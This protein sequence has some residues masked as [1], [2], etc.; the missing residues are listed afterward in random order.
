MKVPISWLREFVEINVTPYELADK[1]VSCGFEVEEII[2]EKESIKNVVT[3]K[4]VDIT[5]HPDATK[6]LICKIDVARGDLLQIVTG[7]NNVFVDA[8]VPVCLDGA[9]L[10]DGKKITTGELR[11]VLSQGMLCSGSELNLDEDDFEGAGVNGIFIMPKDTPIG[12]DIKDYIGCDDIILDISITA[13]RPDCNSIIGIAKEVA[14]LLNT[15]FIE[16]TIKYTTKCD[17]SI[18]VDVIAKD[19]CPNYIAH[20]VDN[21]VITKSPKWMRKRLKLTD[22]KPYNNIVDLTNYMLVEVG[23]PMH[24]FDKDYMDSIIVRRAKEN[25]PFTSLMDDKRVLDENVLVIANSTRPMAVAGVMGGKDSSICDT[26]Q[27]VVLESA[28]FVRESI[29]RTSRRIKL[30]SDSSHRYEK[31]IDLHSQTLAVDRAL[32]IIDSENWGSISSVRSQ[33]L[34]AEPFK[35]T[36]EFSADNIKAILG[37]EIPIKNIND[38]LTALQFKVT[39][40]E[41]NIICEV[42]PSREDI[43]GINDIAEELIRFYGYDKI[44]TTLMDSAKQTIGQLNEKLAFSRLIRNQLVTKGLSEILTYSFTSPKYIGMLG[45]DKDTKLIKLLNPLGEELSVMRT[46]LMNSMLETIKSNLSK[47][48]K[49]AY[50]FEIARSFIAEQLPLNDLPKENNLISIGM[51]GDE[52]DYYSMKNIVD[53]ILAYTT[54]NIEY[55]YSS[56]PYMHTGRSADVFINGV[57]VCSFGELHPV[58]QVRY[59]LSKR[60]YV[61]EIDIDT[62]YNFYDTSYQYKAVS[63]Y[64]TVSRDIAVVVNKEVLSDTLINTIINNG[65]EFITSAKVFDVYEGTQVQ[66]GMKSI[67][68]NMEFSANKTMTEPE[69]VAIMDNIITALKKE[70]NA[71]IRE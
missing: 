54:G 40:K 37:I 25:E 28:K 26:T 34:S 62:L 16:P 46:T 9:V 47:G 51:Y 4:I 65:G 49:S 24:A 1:L 5:K 35:K 18:K 38:I 29:R 15:K 17:S 36:I 70:C 66:H 39:I 10:P 61:C 19:L 64:P 53:G 23:Q 27:S 55:K 52:V 2:D 58:T 71:T 20:Q 60:V 33:V 13:N 69:I 42:P 56:K 43:D 8:I 68:L 44:Q 12:I 30:E 7:A 59:D 50:L 31:G 63:K 41:N 45:L 11:G 57:Q 67:A 14:A 22:H 21:I 48:N 3:G 6:L 32:T